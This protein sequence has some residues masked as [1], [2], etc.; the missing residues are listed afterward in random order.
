MPPGVCLR[1]AYLQIVPLFYRLLF[2][3]PDKR[4][5]L[6]LLISCAFSRLPARSCCANDFSRLAERVKEAM[7]SLSANLHG[8][9]FSIDQARKIGKL[10]ATATVRQGDDFLNKPESRRCP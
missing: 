10:L 7:F 5:Q 8:Q 1:S 3:S 2:Y 4:G 9:R 6:G